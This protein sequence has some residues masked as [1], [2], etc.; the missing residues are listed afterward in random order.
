MGL[1]CQIII[2][3]ATFGEPNTCSFSDVDNQKGNPICLSKIMERA[4]IERRKTVRPLW[5]LRLAG[6]SNK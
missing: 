6:R 1:I 4:L 5:H 3:L 2:R